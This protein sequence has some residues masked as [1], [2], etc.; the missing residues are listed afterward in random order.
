MTEKCCICGK[1]GD[2]ARGDPDIIQTCSVACT[3]AYWQ[4]ASD[5]HSGR[6]EAALRAEI[7]NL[8]AENETLLKHARRQ[9]RCDSGM[10]DHCSGGDYMTVCRCDCHAHNSAA[11]GV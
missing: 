7:V 11:E 10:A 2:W 4:A 3:E 6:T 9:C 1:V 5:R 8:R